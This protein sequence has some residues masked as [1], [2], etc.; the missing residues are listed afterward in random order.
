MD[1]RQERLAHVKVAQYKELSK[2][3]LDWRVEKVAKQL[4]IRYLGQLAATEAHNLVR[5]K[6]IGLATV[7][8][9]RKTVEDH[10]LTYPYQADPEL[11]D[12]TW[13][14]WEMLFSQMDREFY[15]NKPSLWDRIFRNPK[16]MPT[17]RRQFF[18]YCKLLWVHYG[19]C[20]CEK[21]PSFTVLKAPVCSYFVCDG[22]GGL[23]LQNAWPVFRTHPKIAR[24]RLRLVRAR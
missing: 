10:G 24:P 4:D 19:D 20:C 7:D 14:G 1:A 23:S 17:A 18:E 5:I 3:E 15:P 13:A 11:L 2:I 22:C 9:I 12:G 8:L 21:P 6:G 16:R